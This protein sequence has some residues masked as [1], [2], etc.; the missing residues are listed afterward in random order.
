MDIQKLARA[1]RTMAGQLQKQ[2][3][4]ADYFE[5]G[6]PGLVL[7]NPP[8]GDAEEGEPYPEC[9]RKE[10][11]YLRT[12]LRRMEM[13]QRASVVMPSGFLTRSGQDDLS[14]RRELV[15]QCRLSAVVLL[16]PAV[17]SPR[18]NVRTAILVFEKGG[19]SESVRLLDLASADSLAA[20]QE[21]IKR[22]AF[23]G[24]SMTVSRQTL[25][26]RGYALLP[27]YYAAPR[28]T[29]EL[30]QLI[31]KLDRLEVKFHDMERQT[32]MQIGLLGEVPF[33]NALYSKKRLALIREV[34][35]ALKDVIRAEFTAEL[36]A[37]E[38]ASW[39]MERGSALFRFRSGSPWKGKAGR[40]PIYGGGGIRGYGERAIPVPNP[41][42]VVARVGTHSGEVY[43]THGRVW[44]TD[45]ALY[46]DE[47]DLE[48]DYLYSLFLT[49]DFGRLKSGSC[50]PQVSIKLL[51]SLSYPLPPAEKRQAFASR[52][53]PRI[54]RMQELEEL[55]ARPG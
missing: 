13:G 38:N 16:P 34:R 12:L 22:P 39:P 20:F 55:L 23:E 47:T 27:A 24:A 19:A 49:M 41:T 14:L 2:M 30:P 8:F 17:F 35:E 37:P 21:A 36:G 11:L 33:E 28:P 32:P 15:E 5:Y 25:A 40:V 7:L 31:E 50:A 4:R 43:K 10:N 53:A 26:R 54:L 1:V 3:G 46:L 51:M 9:R 6:T 45:N 42:L 44:V 52:I 29:A 18:S 48:I